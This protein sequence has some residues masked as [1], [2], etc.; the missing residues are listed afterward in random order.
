MHSVILKNDSVGDLTKSLGAIN[1]IITSRE[2]QKIT[3]L[4]VLRMSK[5]R[6]K[7]LKWP[8]NTKTPYI[9]TIFWSFSDE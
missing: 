7:Y 2:N 1:N 6:D 9:L 4:E 8:K 5:N 3:I